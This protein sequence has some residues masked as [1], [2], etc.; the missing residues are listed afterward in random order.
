MSKL[1]YLKRQAMCVCV[2][3]KIFVDY[4]VNINR[5]IRRIHFLDIDPFHNVYVQTIIQLFLY[6]NDNKRFP[7]QNPN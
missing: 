1:L 4:N 7:E 2:C 3:V 5:R 6:Q